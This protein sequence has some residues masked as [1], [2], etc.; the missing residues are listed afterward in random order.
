MATASNLN[1]N[2]N[3]NHVFLRKHPKAVTWPTRAPSLSR[4][5]NRAASLVVTRAIDTNQFLGDFG[6]R[7]PF[8]AELES[9]FGEKVLG[10]GSTEHRILIP[11]ISALSLAQQDC[12]PISPLQPPISEQDAQMLVRKVVGWRLVNEEGRHKLQCLWK[13]RDF[14]CGVELINRIS[15]VVEAA[16]HFPNIYLEQPNQ[17]RAELW[18]ASIGGLSMNDFIV[19]AKIDE[20]KTSDL[21]PRKRVWA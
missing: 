3:L 9:S 17:V 12:A 7:D 15:K 21:A 6:A 18:T 10:Y 20:I 5:G 1:L 2:L 4:R 8:P 11:N 14:K 19:A 16:G 13:L